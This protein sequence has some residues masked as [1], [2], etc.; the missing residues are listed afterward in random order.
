MIY[1]IYP[2]WVNQCTR[3][4]MLSVCWKC[5][6]LSLRCKPLIH[7]NLDCYYYYKMQNGYQ[8]SSKGR[9]SSIQP[10]DILITWHWCVVQCK[11]P[12]LGHSWGRTA[13]PNLGRVKHLRA[14]PMSH[15]YLSAVCVCVYSWQ[16]AFLFG[17]DSIQFNLCSVN[18]IH[19]TV[20]KQFPLLN[21]IKYA[22]YT[23]WDALMYQPIIDLGKTISILSASMKIADY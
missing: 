13:L 19:Y 9:W 8:V 16:T 11:R 6:E 4:S 23:C 5:W 21:H 15:A 18:F 17:L 7:F 22:S 20:K 3:M 10:P 2:L 12:L 1:D 14:V